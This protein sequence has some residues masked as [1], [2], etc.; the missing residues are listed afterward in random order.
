MSSVIRTH[1]RDHAR[2][3]R[4]MN[5]HR[6]LMRRRPAKNASL[7]RAANGMGLFN[8]AQIANDHPVDRAISE[9]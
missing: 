4:D 6:S 9:A 2:I 7:L 8:F 1:D 3:A 5:Q